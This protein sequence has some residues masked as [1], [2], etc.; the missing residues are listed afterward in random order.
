ML[1]IDFNGSMLDIDI[2][3]SY[4][5][6]KDGISQTIWSTDFRI[7]SR[8]G[9]FNLA[10]VWNGHIFKVNKHGSVEVSAEGYLEKWLKQRPEDLSAI[11]LLRIKQRDYHL[12]MANTINELIT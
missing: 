10:E 3:S 6:Q 8:T 5:H 2:S 12:S 1:S 11:K 7:S 4:S 9:R